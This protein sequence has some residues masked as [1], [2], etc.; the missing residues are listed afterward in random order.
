MPSIADTTRFMPHPVRPWQA[1]LAIALAALALLRARRRD[2]FPKLSDTAGDNDSLMRLVEVRDLLAGQGWFDLTQY[3]MGPPGGFVMHWSRLV[4]A[5]IAGL[6]LG[7]AVSGSR[8]GG[9]AFALTAWPLLLAGA[10]MFLLMR[11]VRR[12]AGEAAL[13]PAAVIGTAALHYTGQFMP[14]SIDHH[15][16]QIVL[17]LATILRSSRR[18]ARAR[19]GCRRGSGADAGDRHGDGAL[20]G[21]RRPVRGGRLVVE[22]QRRAKHGQ[23]FRPFLR[24]RRARRTGGDGGA[25]RLVLC[26]PATR[27]RAA[28]RARRCWPGW[29][30]RS[31]RQPLPG[32][33][34]PR[35]RAGRAGSSARAFAAL[36]FPHCLG[37]PYAGLD[38]RLKD[39]W[40]GSVIE[41]QSFPS[42]A[43][44]TSHARG[45]L[46]DAAPGA[47]LMV[48]GFLRLRLGRGELIVAGFL[49]VGLLVS[50]WQVR[51]AMFSL[52]LATIPLAAWVGRLRLA[53]RR[54]RPA[55][56]P[57]DGRGMAGLAVDHLGMRRGGRD[58]LST[59]P[60][61]SR[62]PRRLLRQCRLRRARRPAAGTVLAVSNLGPAILANT[63]HRV[64]SGPYHRNVA[65]DLAGLNAFMGSPGEA[66]K[67]VRAEHVTLVANCPGNS[68]TA[69]LAGW[70]PNG[71]AAALDAG[72]VPAWLTPVGAVRPATIYRVAAAAGK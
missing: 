7:Q 6:M 66:E 32:H 50:L 3:R 18:R 49:A 53:T 31:P 20:C 29:G 25:A 72:R 15:S 5:P 4:D 60:T 12:L 58:Q 2:G 17:M 71:F 54:H 51:G 28:R 37:D 68:E 34:P 52:P 33:A 21:G 8:A 67:M 11:I 39:F 63:P 44:R 56:Q 14:G 61:R 55:A 41:A 27:S 57:D 69:A 38:P 35:R 19:R 48:A 43:V 46:C 10:A 23:A 64:L 40:L 70:A 62:L 47:G 9:E 36:V 59:P 24:R 26:H 30:W 65:G 16:T 1:D 42:L 13:L 22:R 45:L